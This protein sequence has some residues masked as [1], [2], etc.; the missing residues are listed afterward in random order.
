MG[1]ERSGAQ[2][3]CVMT[4]AL[5]PTARP[6]CHK[7]PAHAN[8]R[9]WMDG[10]SHRYS[11]AHKED[12]LALRRA[13]RLVAPL[14]AQGAAP[15]SRRAQRRLRRLRPHLLRG[16]GSAHGAERDLTFR[17]VA[18]A[19]VDAGR[20]AT[21]RD[22][23]ARVR[24]AAKRA[25][26][27]ETNLILGWLDAFGDVVVEHYQAKAGKAHPGMPRAT[28][29]LEA[30]VLEKV[31]HQV[32]PRAGY[33][34]N[35]RRLDITL[36]LMRLELAGKADPVE[37]ATVIRDHYR[38]NGF[39]SGAQ[40]RF[41]RD[42]EGTSSIDDLILMSDI[43]AAADRER[44]QAE[45][46][47]DR[48]RQRQEESRLARIEA[49]LDPSNG[50]PRRPDGSKVGAYRSLTGKVVADFPDLMEIWD[51]EKNT[52]NPNE[53]KA[54]VL[55]RAQWACPVHESHRWEA[56][57]KDKASYP[58]GCPFCMDRR[59]CPT[60]SVA[61]MYPD[62]AKE[63]HPTRNT[64]TADDYVKGANVK[65]WWKCRKRHI[66]EARIDARTIG[67]QQCLTCRRAEQK[68]AREVTDRD[69]AA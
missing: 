27:R 1:S 24:R 38:A 22:A 18:D 54:S 53:T 17:E 68:T 23:A 58:V 67:G 29:S 11:D 64:M 57:I 66:W 65:V 59:P 60:N 56:T 2:A 69:A 14:H 51:W 43:A 62:V 47:K 5:T 26:V 46:N 16:R 6:K 37:Y 63:W 4:F 13:Q 15:P 28:G 21:Y 31:T 35:R 45:A 32:G 9:V 49:G 3:G 40:W 34:R 42:P 39:R 7:D 12:P 25:D 50:R 61:A 33:F 19:L 44:E 10:T 55:H 20:G 36:G 52:L 48:R 30:A 41:N 8:Y